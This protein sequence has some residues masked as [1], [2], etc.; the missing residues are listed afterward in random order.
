MGFAK[1]MAS[2]AGR[3]LRIVVG[4]ALIAYGLL[5]VHGTTGTVLA[6]VGLVPLALGAFNICI[7]GPLLGAPL[8]G[9]DL[10]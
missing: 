8:R 6:L 5:A 4:L 10:K 1:F 2:A 7:L 9:S 3:G